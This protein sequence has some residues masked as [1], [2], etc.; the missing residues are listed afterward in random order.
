MTVEEY[1][2][3]AYRLDQMINSDIAETEQ[4]KQMAQGVTSPSWGEKVQGSSSGE[5]PQT[6]NIEKLITLEQKINSE[7]DLL[8]DLKEQ[9][10]DVISE[11]PDIN[12]QMV[13]R[14]RYIA[15]L[16]WLQAASKMN[17]GESTVRRWHR[18][19]LRHVRLPDDPICVLN[20]CRSC[21]SAKNL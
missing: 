18:S 16:T 9:M 15:G 12:E 5:S 11:V 3:Q 17:A 21:R 13:L 2:S 10:R 19:A 20:V 14:H 7:I 6:R 1:L 4:I 8:V